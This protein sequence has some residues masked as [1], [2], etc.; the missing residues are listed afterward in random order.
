MNNQEIKI[1]RKRLQ[2]TQQQFAE[3][4]DWSKS[5][6]SMIET[7]KRTITKKS[8]EKYAKHSIWTVAFYPWKQK[9]IFF[10]FDSKSTPLLK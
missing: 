4:L 6:L 5:Y 2:L 10:V 3:K 7:G 9:L 1:L 8:I